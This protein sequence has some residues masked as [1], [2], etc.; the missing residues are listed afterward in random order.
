MSFPDGDMQNHVLIWGKIFFSVSILETN[1]SMPD[2]LVI[3]TL[4]I[5]SCWDPNLLIALQM[6]TTYILQSLHLKIPGS[7]S[8]NTAEPQKVN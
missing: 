4:R 6:Q 7:A 2:I 3:I 8:N 1:G 5:T